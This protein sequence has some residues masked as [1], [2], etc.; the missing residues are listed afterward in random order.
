MI[1]R[2]RGPSLAVTT[3]IGKTEIGPGTLV[4]GDDVLTVVVRADENERPVRVRFASIDG[5]GLDG[6]AVTLALR[7]GQRVTFVSDKG[8]AL[9]A[10]LLARCRTLPELTRT[11]RAF[12]SRRGLAAGRADAGEQQRFFAPLIAARRQAVLAES[13]GEAIGAFD[14]LTLTR[15]LDATLRRFA[16]ERYSENGPERR[17]FEAALVD[18]CEPL[19]ASI[20][21]LRGLAD[22]ARGS[23]DDL[24]RW[25][26]WAAQL[27]VMFEVA[28]RVWIAVDS[29][30][31]GTPWQQ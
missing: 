25:R 8:A 19:H 7:D 13:A 9:R 1:E 24:K 2:S 16:H 12:G 27:R 26:A 4:L 21:V 10:D 15:A 31:I 18:A 3:R 29:A 5:I 23:V 22:E 30:L 14:C 17:A 20:A 11:L 6:S 28:D